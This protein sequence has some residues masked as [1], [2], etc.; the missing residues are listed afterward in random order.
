MSWC[1]A[2]FCGQIPPACRL[3]SL[4]I[5]DTLLHRAVGDPRDVFL[6][7]G[8]QAISEGL[9]APP[10]DPHGFAELRV[11]MQRRARQ[12]ARSETG[13]SEVTLEHIWA[14]APPTLPEPGRLLELELEV[15]YALSFP[16]PYTR[17]FLIT[18]GA[19]G[20]SLCLTSDT[21]FSR[22]FIIRL[23]AKAGISGDA[24]PALVLSNEHCKSKT[25]GAL[26]GVLLD[27]VA[28]I[29]PDEIL[30]IGDNLS[31]DVLQPRALGLHARH[32]S[33]AANQ[34]DWREREA[35]LGMSQSNGD[36]SRAA[37]G[38][39][40]LPA[41]SPDVTADPD[42]VALFDLGAMVL[43]PP[44]AFF[45][46]WVMQDAIARRLEL[47]C[48]VMREATVFGPLLRAA[49]QHLGHPIPVVDFYVSRRA[50]FVPAMEALDAR[51]LDHYVRRRHFRLRDLIR[52]L[53]LPLPDGALVGRLDERLRDLVSDPAFSAWVSSAPVQEQAR[54]AS[55][56]AR[57]LLREYSQQVLGP[58][59][60]VGFVDLG[61]NGDT[62][63]N[64]AQSIADPKAAE[65]RELT[66]YLFHA[67]ANA[68]EHVLDG[69][70]FLSFFGFDPEGL[71]LAQL[72]NRSHE[73]I[74]VLLTQGIGTTL[75]YRRNAAG[76]VEPVTA[77]WVENPPQQR[78]IDSGRRGMT[79]AWQHV[80]HAT[81]FVKPEHFLTPA[82]RL[83]LGRQLERLLELPTAAEAR[84]IGRLEFED[85]VG[86][87]ARSRICTEADQ[88]LL[89]E[90]GPEAFM[91]RARGGW[92]Y[93]YDEL[94]W[95]QGVVTAAYPGFL[96]AE[97]RR[98]FNDTDY[99]FLAQTLVERALEQ[100][101]R[102]VAL[103]GAGQIGLTMLTAAR[104][105]GLAIVAVVDSNPKLHGLRLLGHKIISLEEA[106]RLGCD[107]Y[108]VASVAF[109]RAI[110]E[111]I[112]RCYEN[113]QLR[114]PAILA[115]GR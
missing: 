99:R 23:L 81:A 53:R 37:R 108:L 51:A 74:E 10:L 106:M 9:L 38:L 82:A 83:A 64:L 29:K 5:F 98:L 39:G 68:L 87:D 25:D 89:A 60:R 107:G 71:R 92:G 21:Y 104:E 24:F 61:P 31:S 95:P 77:H 85:N 1:D 111:T 11:R 76:R 62:L 12:R 78:L 102:K 17:D 4:D 45:A 3:I 65:K 50:A 67:K 105:Q 109:A 73:V 57:A 7:L 112:R 46:L 41:A 30:H 86:T 97:R 22:A 18:A 59:A 48:P 16:N 91:Q 96:K 36:V 72:V 56:E 44:L 90:L 6:Y 26:F 47:L 101:L 8:E 66:H 55:A 88:A 84:A 110:E 20:I 103:Y 93:L 75:G 58:A 28:P 15:E 79:L 69:H 54:I 63:A 14:E 40:S 80:A 49:G 100:G 115:L 2:T 113:R 13:S 52:E 19:R 27:Q 33:V 42:G 32:F 70:R 34:G 114:V 94:R 43:G 35:L